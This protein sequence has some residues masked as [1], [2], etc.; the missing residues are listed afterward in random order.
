MTYSDY[1]RLG[2]ENLAD[3]WA[4]SIGV[5]LVALLLGG[6][7]G[8][9]SVT[10]EINIHLKDQDISSLSDLLN[11]ITASGLGFSLGLGSILG[12]VQFIMGGAVELGY[13]RYLLNQYRHGD[14]ELNDLF[15]QFYRFGQGFAQAFLRGL[16]TFLWA[17][18]FIIPGIVKSY[19][20]AMTPYI[21]AD[22][23]ELTASEAITASKQ[24][25]DGHKAD[26][27]VLEL[28]FIG[29]DLLCALTLNIGYIVLNP[30][31]AAARTAFYK[32]LTAQNRI[33][34]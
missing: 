16:Y 18:L 31:K 19:A 8:G 1:R 25:M 9:T 3:N 6:L 29:W 7:I 17:L 24:M 14:F 5:A 21:M 30:Y 27:F 34:E 13:A 33:Y 10:P 23:P 11:L 22:N 20:Y 2:R 12:L 4:K 26:L 32:S 15:S 28:T